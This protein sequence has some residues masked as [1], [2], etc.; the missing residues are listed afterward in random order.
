MSAAI[1]ETLSTFIDLKAQYAALVLEQSVV[2]EDG[3][4]AAT[5]ARLAVLDLALIRWEAAYRS[6][7]R[8]LECLCKGMTPRGSQNWLTQR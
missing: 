2:T 1:L 6:A 4:P 3:M 8:R 5:P 7:L